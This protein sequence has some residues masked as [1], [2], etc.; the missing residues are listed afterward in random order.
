MPKRVLLTGAG[1]FIGSHVLRHLLLETDW[2]VVCT[3]SF[4]HKGK[5]DRITRQANTYVC[6]DRYEVIT[7]DLTVPFSEQMFR[8]V[9]SVNYVIAMAS[10]SHVD[11][12]IEDPAGF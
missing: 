12:S 8:R 7:H 6:G 5:T 4:R 9:G 10:Q 3:D 11:R 1:G 2:H